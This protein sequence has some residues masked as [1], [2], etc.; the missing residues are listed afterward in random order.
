M[1]HTHALARLLEHGPLTMAELRA[2][3]G[4][5]YNAIRSALARLIEYRRVFFTGRRHGNRYALA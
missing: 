1:T 4:W 3:T 5:P 2:I